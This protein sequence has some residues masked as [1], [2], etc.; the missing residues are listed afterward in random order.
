[1]SYNVAEVTEME[2]ELCSN[3]YVTLPTSQ[4]IF[5]PFCHFTYVTAHSQ[6]LPSLN[7]HH[8][9]FSNPSFASSTSQLIL[10]PFFRFFYVRG[11]SLTSPGEPPCLEVTPMITKSNRMKHVKMALWCRNMLWNE[12]DAYNERIEQDIIYNIL[13]TKNKCLLNGKI[14][15]R[16]NPKDIVTC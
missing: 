4:F 2:N 15:S 12:T 13:M 9:S 8:S 16:Q 7:L 10:Q 3:L 14:S 1:M 5:Q 11:S 6:T